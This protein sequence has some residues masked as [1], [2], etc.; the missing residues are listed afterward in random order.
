MHDANGDLNIF[1]HWDLPSFAA[2]GNTV[3]VIMWRSLGSMLVDERLYGES[4]SHPGYINKTI[5][6][7]PSPV[8]PPWLESM[9]EASLIRTAQVI[10]RFHEMI[11]IKYIIANVSS[12]NDKIYTNIDLYKFIYLYKFIDD[13]CFKSLNFG[14]V[15]YVTLENWYVSEKEIKPIYHMFLSQDHFDQRWKKSFSSVAQGL[16][17]YLYI[18]CYVKKWVTLKIFWFTKYQVRSKIIHF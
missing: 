7:D 5:T 18:L 14:V 8:N 10:C 4:P 16:S 13:K 17:N 2:L 6:K 15:C 3:T 1:T 9:S 12:I 11:M